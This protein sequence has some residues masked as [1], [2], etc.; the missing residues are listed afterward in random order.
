L[1]RCSGA[2]TGEGPIAASILFTTNLV[3]GEWL[4]LIGDPK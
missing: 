1:A 4:T 3:F 2:T